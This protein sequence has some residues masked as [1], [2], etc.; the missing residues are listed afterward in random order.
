M[1]TLMS[2]T[3]SWLGL[4]HAGVGET[5]RGI[6]LASRGLTLASGM[7]QTWYEGIA[8]RILGILPEGKMVSGVSR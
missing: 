7:H 2:A 1:K 4:A 3:L 8:Q 5:D 6:E